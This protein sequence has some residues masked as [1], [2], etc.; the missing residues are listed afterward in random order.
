M[1][2]FCG[3]PIVDNLVGK[4]WHEKCSIPSVMHS[5]SPKNRQKFSTA[6]PAGDSAP[7]DTETDASMPPETDDLA[8]IKGL[9]DT[10][11][12]DQV[13]EVCDYCEQ[14]QSESGGEEGAGDMSASGEGEMPAAVP[15]GGASSFLGVS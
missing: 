10:L 4:S 9:I 2:A 13:Q 5:F 6:K 1:I 8:E 15:G 7:A 3:M 11:S 12:P 14:K